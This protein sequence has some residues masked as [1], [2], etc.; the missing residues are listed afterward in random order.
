LRRA[1]SA[2]TEFDYLFAENGLDAFKNGELLAVQS[3]KAALGE[4]NLKVGTFV[5][6]K[7]E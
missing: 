3:L 7:I 1:A 4:D 6:I 5:F 2:K